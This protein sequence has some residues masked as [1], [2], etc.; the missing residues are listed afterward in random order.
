MGAKARNF[1]SEGLATGKLG[2]KEL[3]AKAGDF[4]AEGSCTNS[5]ERW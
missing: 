4:E 1:E 3:G 5:E 2:A